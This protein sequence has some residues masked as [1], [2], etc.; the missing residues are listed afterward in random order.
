MDRRISVFEEH[1]ERRV[2]ELVKAELRAMLEILDE[3][4]T[5]EEFL[6]V[7]RIIVEAGEELNK[8]GA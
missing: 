3:R 2:A 5:E 6:K 1:I 7:A 4:L 8:K